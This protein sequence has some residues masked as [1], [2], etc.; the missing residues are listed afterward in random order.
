MKNTQSLLLALA[1]P[2]LLACTWAALGDS[3]SPVLPPPQTWLAQAATMLASGELLSAV[4]AT[5]KTVLLSTVIAGIAGAALGAL[6]GARQAV[7]DAVAPTL[8][9]LRAVPPP[10]IVPVAMLLIGSGR[11]LDTSVVALAAVWPI[12]MNVLHATRSLHPT[13]IDTGRTLRMSARSKLINI[14]VPSLLPALIAGLR[15]AVPLAII[16]SLLVEMLATRPGIGRL[17]LTAQ[18]DF[19]APTVFALLLTVGLVGAAVNGA[20]QLLER[21]VSR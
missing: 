3:S 19:D 8:E 17:L 12:L 20:L 10:T 7:C 6:L 11:V 13:L 2:L 9:F 18:R 4:M 5:L 21:S 1:T 14:L 15:V 16:V